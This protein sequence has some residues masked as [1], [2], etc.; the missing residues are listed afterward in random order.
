M[1]SDA[2]N[3]YYTLGKRL[4]LTVGWREKEYRAKNEMN[5]ELK[6]DQQKMWEN[7]LKKN[8]KVD[9]AIAVAGLKAALLIGEKTSTY[10]VITTSWMIHV[11]NSIF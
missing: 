4:V 5:K 6:M 10:L 2:C 8:S 11:F 7:H 9:N 1:R 3:L